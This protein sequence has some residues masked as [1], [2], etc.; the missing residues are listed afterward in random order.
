MHRPISPQRCD[1]TM[2]L[3]VGVQGIHPVSCSKTRSGSQDKS[4]GFEVRTQD[5]TLEL[6]RAIT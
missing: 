2:D 6:G 4:K 5:G 3:V 1:A